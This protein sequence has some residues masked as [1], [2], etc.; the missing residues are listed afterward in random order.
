[1]Q[2]QHGSLDCTGDLQIDTKPAGASQAKSYTTAKLYVPP[3]AK[4]GFKPLAG[5]TVG[6]VED[7]PRK[8]WKALSRRRDASDKAPSTVLLTP[9]KGQP[10]MTAES[11]SPQL[12]EQQQQ[13]GN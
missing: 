5:D 1:V 7:Y 12:P 9:T 10:A 6:Q 11:D 3:A 2:A 4:Q 13:R 8:N